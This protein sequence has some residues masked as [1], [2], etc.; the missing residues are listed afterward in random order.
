MSNLKDSLSDNPTSKT[1]T[2][3]IDE[4]AYITHLQQY[5]QAKLT[6]IQEHLAGHYLSYLAVNKFELD[7]TKEF[8]F[9]YHPELESDNLIITERPPA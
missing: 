5:M 6:E 8:L 4:V 9:E 7:P 2:L 1:V 3:S